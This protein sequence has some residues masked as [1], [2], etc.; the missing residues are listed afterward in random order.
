M[1]YNRECVTCRFIGACGL[2]NPERILSHFVC[3]NFE[4]V[5]NAVEIVKAR[6]DIIN[7]FGTAGLHALAPNRRKPPDE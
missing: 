3:T 1:T 2:T 7:L 6:C 4:E 5:E